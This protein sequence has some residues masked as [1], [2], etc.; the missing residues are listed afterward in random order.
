MLLA[1]EAQEIYK[2][3]LPSRLLRKIRRTSGMILILAKKRTI[4]AISAYSPCK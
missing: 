3:G 2:R 1:K 4:I